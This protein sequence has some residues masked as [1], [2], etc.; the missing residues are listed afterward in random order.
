MGLIVKRTKMIVS[1]L[2]MEWETS[3]DVIKTIFPEVNNAA[4]K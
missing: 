3:S 4:S 1:H 2:T